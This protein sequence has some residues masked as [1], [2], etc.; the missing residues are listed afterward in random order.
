MTRQPSDC[1]RNLRHVTGPAVRT[2]ALIAVS[3]TTVMTALPVE[4]VAAAIHM[5]AAAK[6][7]TAQKPSA[8]PLIHRVQAD[9][10][11]GRK[12][13]ISGVK[14][15]ENKR[16][17]TAVAKFSNAMSGGGLSSQDM[18][19]A[20]Y[21][22]A[23]AYQLSNQPAQAIA[24]YTSVLWLKNGLTKDERASAE[25]LRAKAYKSAGIRGA[26]TPSSTADAA[27]QRTAAGSPSSPSGKTTTTTTVPPASS[28]P[29]SGIGTMFTGLFNGIGSATGAASTTAQ[30]T[31]QA[32]A[33]PPATASTRP[34]AA[35][36]AW[37]SATQTNPAATAASAAR[38]PAP[39]PAARAPVARAPVV[40]P[41]APPRATVSTP[42]STAASPAPV[43]SP[44][45]V[46]TAPPPQP[47]RQIVAPAP[48]RS[49]P[50]ARAPVAA[51][52]VRTAAL[53]QAQRP[54]TPKPAVGSINL[55]VAAVRS[56]GEAERLVARIAQN[57]GAQLGN[58]RPTIQETV[59]GN[60]GT[61]YRVKVGPFSKQAETASLCQSLKS[62]GYDCLVTTQ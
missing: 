6:P 54:A 18:A 59:Y 7:V 3:A 32:P 28:N 29:F 27:Q 56:R 50:A 38:I 62:G 35:V 41:P 25:A 45:P 20:M 23:Q 16:Y 12:L 52:P 31:T 30:A 33:A 43:T 34:V 49:P 47:T 26:P 51:P 8:P 39:P 58:R 61:F 37:N 1:A 48:V 21:Y 14:A 9:A 13:V 22:R 10:K 11:A 60:M 4:S 2:M 36:S 19:K 24:D 53:P 57:Y 40:R 17:D 5:R 15:F 46:R 42:W 44:A 55:Q